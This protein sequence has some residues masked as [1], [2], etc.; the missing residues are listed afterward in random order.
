[1]FAQIKIPYPAFEETPLYPY[2]AILESHFQLLNALYLMTT[3][4]RSSSSCSAATCTSRKP[5]S[6]ELGLAKKE[7]N[8][9]A[10]AS[11]ARRRRPPSRAAVAEIHY[12][13]LVVGF[14]SWK[15]AAIEKSQEELQCV[16]CQPSKGPWVRLTCGID[17]VIIWGSCSEA[18]HD[19]HIL[20]M[21]T[22]W[23]GKKSWPFSNHLIMELRLYSFCSQARVVNH[24][25]YLRLDSIL[26]MTRW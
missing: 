22:S 17:S 18:W 23:H 21:E 12:I 4:A 2:G 3:T 15:A 24:G 13:V 26:I 25:N 10:A 8:S 9:E 20:C 1:M 16:C 7:S 11:V 5:S 19:Q 14:S 6:W